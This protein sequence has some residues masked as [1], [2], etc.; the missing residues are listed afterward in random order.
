MENVFRE[1]SFSTTQYMVNYVN[2]PDYKKILFH[3]GFISN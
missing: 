2:I 3:L 1:Q